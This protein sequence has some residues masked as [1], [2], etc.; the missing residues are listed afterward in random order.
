MEAY[1]P[2]PKFYWPC[3]WLQVQ[4]GQAPQQPTYR[5]INPGQQPG[6]QPQHRAPQLPPQNAYTPQYKTQYN[7]PQQQPN[8]NSIYR[9]QAPPQGQYQAQPSGSFPKNLPPHIQK[10]IESQRQY[11]GAFT[12]QPY[13]NLRIMQN[14][15][16]QI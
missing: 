5:G 10:I 8:P 9:P 13:F 6:P 2:Y 4:Y 1:L 11:Q 15:G 7:G 3:S 14:E 12:Y 16:E